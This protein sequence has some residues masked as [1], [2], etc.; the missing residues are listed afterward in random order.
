M[1]YSDVK[2][3]KKMRAPN[4]EMESTYMSGKKS[5]ANPRSMATMT[6]VSS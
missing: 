1:N 6:T 2:M 4:A 5:K 3:I